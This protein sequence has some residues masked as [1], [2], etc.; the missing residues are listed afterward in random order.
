M[1]YRTNSDLPAD[2]FDQY[3]ERQKTAARLVLNKVMHKTGD[4]SE[5]FKQAHA[6]AK[7]TGG[8]R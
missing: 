1:P 2:Q 7:R 5:A 8:G 3:D 4:E 6:A